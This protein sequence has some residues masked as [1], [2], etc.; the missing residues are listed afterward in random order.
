ML[1]LLELKRTTDH[2]ADFEKEATV[3][4]ERQYE[5]VVGAQTE[6]GRSMGRGWTVKLLRLVR[7]TSWLVHK[8]HTEKNRWKSSKSS[9]Q[10]GKGS[11]K[12]L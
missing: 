5:D 10:S 8:E 11:G 2:R 1:Y 12:D 7:G 6:V 3:R 9:S 4:D